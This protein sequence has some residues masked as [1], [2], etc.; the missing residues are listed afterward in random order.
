ML[1]DRLRRHMEEVR[2]YRQAQALKRRHRLR[3]LRT[4]V[5]LGLLGGAAAA[6][7]LTQ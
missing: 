1:H 4:V 7:V 2:R 6:V 3:W 5:F